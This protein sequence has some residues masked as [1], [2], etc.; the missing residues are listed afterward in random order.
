MKSEFYKEEVD[1]REEL[2]A[3]IMNNAALI[4]QE[5]QDNLRRATSTIAKRVKMC[6][7]VD[8]G[9]FSTYFK[10]LQFIES[11]YITNKCNQ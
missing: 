2:V 9:I 8:Y 4:K 7:V 10:L 11:I 6:I 5:R 3:C 1:K